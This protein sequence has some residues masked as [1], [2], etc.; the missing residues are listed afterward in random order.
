MTENKIRN[1]TLK[2]YTQTWNYD[3]KMMPTIGDK[4]IIDFGNGMGSDRRYPYLVE[5]INEEI[6]G[7]YKVFYVEGRQLKKDGS[8]KNNWFQLLFTN[9]P[10]N[11]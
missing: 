1:K 4:I 8:L 10:K 7:N 9:K 3:L 2:T 6:R 11:K 5:T